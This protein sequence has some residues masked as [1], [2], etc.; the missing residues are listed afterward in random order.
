[1]PK[2]DWSD[3]DIEFDFDA[4]LRA[5]KQTRLD[6]QAKAVNAGLMTPNEGRAAE[7]LEPKNGGDKIYLNGTLVPAGQTRE[8]KPNGT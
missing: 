4:L 2:S 7:G 6:A 1:M 5:D 3:I 8:S